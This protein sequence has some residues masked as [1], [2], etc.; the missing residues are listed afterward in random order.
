M[1][2]CYAAFLQAD[3]YAGAIF[4]EQALGWN[5]YLSISA[6]LILAAVFTI[7]GEH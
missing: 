6:L 4:L 3:L 5:L 7:C 1:S 2:C